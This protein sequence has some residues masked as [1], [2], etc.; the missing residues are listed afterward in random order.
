MYLYLSY[1][2]ISVI[3]VSQMHLLGQ[4]DLPCGYIH[5]PILGES[6]LTSL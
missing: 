5:L 3:P 1:P 4:V 6:F 2:C